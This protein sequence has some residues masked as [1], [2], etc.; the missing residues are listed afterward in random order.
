MNLIIH[1]SSIVR[2]EASGGKGPTIIKAKTPTMPG[3]C[4]RSLQWLPSKRTQETW[5]DS[6]SG[7]GMILDCGGH[8][9]N[10]GWRHKMFSISCG[11]VAHDF[12][13]FNVMNTGF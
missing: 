5:G 10:I 9:A 7:V 12:F 4:A 13:G 1:D 11:R 8:S 2:G 3:A 6:A